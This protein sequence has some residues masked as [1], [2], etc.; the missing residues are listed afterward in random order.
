MKGL[1]ENWDL[2]FYPLEK[3]RFNL[4]G[5]GFGNKEVNR[6]W[7]WLNTSILGISLFSLLALGF[8]IISALGIRIN[9]PL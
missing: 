8:F 1:N 2:P 6:D 7:D 4:L 3:I 5:L 9:T